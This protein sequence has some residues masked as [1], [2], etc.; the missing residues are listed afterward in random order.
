MALTD[1]ESGRLTVTI[2]CFPESL[3]RYQTEHAVVAVD[4]IR[5]TTTAVS[6]VVGG[7]RCFP[8]SS[9]DAAV[10]LARRWQDALLVGELGGHTPYGFH[11]TNSPAEFAAPQSGGGRP[12]ILLSTS[13]TRL[14]C[15]ASQ[16]A[17]VYAA[18]L[19]NI[20]AQAE[21]LVARHPKVAIVGAGARGEFRVE[22][23]LA[24]AWIAALLVDAGYRPLG[25]T[26]EII[27]RWKSAPAETIVQGNS[28]AFL[29][30][31][32]QLRDLEYI[33]GH[34]DDVHTSF[35]MRGEEL[36]SELTDVRSLSVARCSDVS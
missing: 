16:D 9:I 32:G 23:Q 14:L 15:E 6:A 8:A 34:I 2:D 21:T 3:S 19:R 17:A 33:L 1:S 28:A 22:D 24:C 12:I 4:V 35:E 7:W 29:R 5:A 26:A 10:E 30:R 31:T 11:L 25:E 13:G 18:C 20:T 27:H 36:V